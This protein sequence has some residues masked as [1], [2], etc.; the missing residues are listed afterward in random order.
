MDKKR[1]GYPCGTYQWYQL[2]VLDHLISL[3]D[4][5]MIVLYINTIES[6]LLIDDVTPT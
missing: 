4:R 5:Q 3:T 2:I 1:D 6:V